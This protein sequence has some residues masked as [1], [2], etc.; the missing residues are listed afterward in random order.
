MT[1]L[2]VFDW[3]GTLL[4][5]MEATHIATN[6]SLAFF[7]K[8]P[9][10]RQQEQEDFSFPLI[11]FYEKMGVSVDQYLEHAEE[12]GNLFNKIYT[13]ESARCGLREGARE[14]LDWLK[15]H[16][17][18][19]TILSNHRDSLLQADVARLGIAEYFDAISGNKNPAT[20]VQGLSKQVRLEEYLN[21]QGY[22]AE[23]AFI[24]GDSHEEPELA[25]RL[26]L[27]SISISGGLM[28][29]E[30]L[31]RVGA[32]FRVDSMAEV[33]PIVEKLWFSNDNDAT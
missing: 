16:G 23:R 15:G 27:T 13:E 5:D 20:I 3:N 24:I 32:D 29:E 19:C 6:A 33:R 14:L 31:I 17:V 30:R 12:V 1:H 9:I 18:V 28:T 8:A 10:T 26:G 11:H 21:A 25:R 4:N 2:A 7:G 22:R